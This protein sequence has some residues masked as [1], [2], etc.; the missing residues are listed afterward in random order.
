MPP[1]TTD[2]GVDLEVALAIGRQENAGV[3]DSASWDEQLWS[4]T[5]TTLGDWVDVTCDVADGVAL[6]AGSDDA[7]G[8]VTRWEAATATLTLLGAQWDPW[9]GVCADLLGPQLPLRVRWRLSDPSDPRGHVHGLTAAHSAS[10]G[11]P[12]PW[13]EAFTGHVDNQGYQ[14]DPDTAS[15]GVVAVDATSALVGFDGVEQAET[16]AGESASAR[17]HRILDL[18]LWPADA[19][20]IDP[21]GVALKATTLADVAWTMLLQVADTDLALLWVRRDGRVSYR[22]QGRVGEGVQIGGRLVVCPDLDDDVQVLTMGRAQPTVVRNIA[23]VSRTKRT[24]DDVPYTA[25]VTD[26]PSVARYGAHRYARTDLTH[27]DDD[28]S[29]V[30]AGAIVAAGAWPSAAPAQVQLTSQLGDPRVAVSL[31]SAE[32]DM[33]FDVVDT[34]AR[35]WRCGVVGWDVDVRHH[36]ITGTFW[37]DDLT[38]WRAGKWDTAGWDRDRWGIGRVE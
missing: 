9:T 15:A 20:D 38:R 28:W 30:V 7:D 22:P 3:W 34:H 29:T 36:Q 31:L 16:G 10:A 32:P 25:T 17:V 35:T 2:Y 13:V 37:I 8:V 18:A 12:H 26:S 23:S 24:E 27:Q 21:G 11:D 5:D 4:Q 14:W 1:T 33:A 6:N 19:R